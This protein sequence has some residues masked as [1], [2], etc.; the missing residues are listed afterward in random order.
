MPHQP[1]MFWWTVFLFIQLVSVCSTEDYV[2][3]ET[4]KTLPTGAVEDGENFQ[5]IY[6]FTF[7]QNFRCDDSTQVKT[8]IE[9]LQK[10]PKGDN[11]LCRMRPSKRIEL[12]CRRRQKFL[13]EEHWIEQTLD[14]FINE[15][16]NVHA[17][18][19]AQCVRDL[20]D[21]GWL[22]LPAISTS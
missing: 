15:T 1:V 21:K 7:P 13:H 3:W 8:Y 20:L 4:V 5:A 14:D 18:T 10:P 6:M 16:T 17:K 11:D 9:Y 19:A 2:P 22:D 12:R